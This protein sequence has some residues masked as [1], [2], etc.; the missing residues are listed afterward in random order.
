MSVVILMDFKQ[1][2]K[3]SLSPKVLAVAKSKDL[4]INL[5]YLQLC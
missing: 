1:K 3:N 5:Y 4:K 2:F